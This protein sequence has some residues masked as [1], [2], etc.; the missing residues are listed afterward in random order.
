[1]VGVVGVALVIGVI[2]LIAVTVSSTIRLRSK[3][4]IHDFPGPALR[5]AQVSQQHRQEEAGAH[6]HGLQGV[7][8][9]QPPLASTRWAMRCGIVVDALR[10]PP[11]PAPWVPPPPPPPPDGAPRPSLKG[12]VIRMIP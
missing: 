4:H 9:K 8:E 11:A 3:I 10:R 12:A 5:V 2:V 1:V 7:N 6:G